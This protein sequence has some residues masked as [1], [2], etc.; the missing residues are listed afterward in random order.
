M[1]IV[2]AINKTVWGVP[3]LLLVMS[4]G[5][6]LS[7]RLGFFQITKFPLWSRETFGTLLKRQKKA[8]GRITPYQAVASALA[9]SIG[10]G[11]IVGVATAITAGGA[12]AVFWMWVSAL[13]GMATKYAEIFLSVKFRMERNGEY[14]GGPMY[15]IKRGLGKGYTWLSVLFAISGAFACLGMGAMNQSNSISSVVSFFIGTPEW[16]TGL[17]VATIAAV[18]M[19]GGIS[20]ISHFAEKM[21]PLMAGLYIL[22]GVGIIVLSP[23][24]AIDALHEICASALTPQAVYGAGAGEM[25]KKAIRF[26]VAR[27][28]FSNEAGLGSA[29]LVHAAAD[30]KSPMHQG[31][32]GMFEVFV[33]TI[34]VCTVTAIAVIGSGCHNGEASGAALVTRAFQ[35]FFGDFGGVFVAV[36]TVLFALSTILGWSYYGEQCVAYLSHENERLS[37]AYQGVFVAA[38]ALGAVLRVESV[39]EIG[40]MF[41]GIM[42]IPNLIA[43]ILLSGIVIRETKKEL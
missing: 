2:A 16:V 24:S 11:N 40:D 29:P 15:Y 26:G 25:V 32:W 13:L 38:V 42:M 27:G 3:M 34:I 1:Q 21:V 41:N 4:C 7:A 31:F 20:R 39:W 6:Y 36:A 8:N 23:G 28:V 33:D 19:S 14:Y 37:K 35:A 30:A 5:I 12:G 22:G 18:A 17:L 9:S 10:T 43:V